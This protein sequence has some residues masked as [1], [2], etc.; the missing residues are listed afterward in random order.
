ML[1]FLYPVAMLKNICQWHFVPPGIWAGTSPL[2]LHIW[3]LDRILLHRSHCRVWTRSWTIWWYLPSNYW[4]PLSFHFSFDFNWS[5]TFSSKQYYLLIWSLGI[6]AAAQSSICHI[7]GVHLQIIA[8]VT[9]WS[10]NKYRGVK[11][12]SNSNAAGGQDLIP[13]MLRHANHCIFLRSHNERILP[14]QDLVASPRLSCYQ[15]EDHNGYSGLLSDILYMFIPCQLTL[16]IDAPP[17]PP[18]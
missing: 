10:T 14:S 4:R 8:P 7:P 11:S 13:V 6:L 18:T 9:A 12:K 16:R 15:S 1:I 2:P 5:Q 3:F 17:P